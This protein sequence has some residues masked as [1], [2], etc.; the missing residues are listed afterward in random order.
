MGHDVTGLGLLCFPL[1]TLAL[2]GVCGC[3]SD[4]GLANLAFLDLFLLCAKTENFI[5]TFHLGNISS[6]N[7]H[8]KMLLVNRIR[9]D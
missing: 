3:L 9:P 7:N 4:C 8:F 5:R 6:C 1:L 2:F